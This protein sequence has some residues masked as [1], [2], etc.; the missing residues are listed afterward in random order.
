MQLRGQGIAAIAFVLAG[1]LV[2]HE[3][4]GQ[5]IQPPIDLFQHALQIGFVIGKLGLLSV[6]QAEKRLDHRPPLWLA[7]HRNHV[8]TQGHQLRHEFRSETH[9]VEQLPERRARIVL[10][11]NLRRW[12]DRCRHHRRWRL[13]ARRI[14]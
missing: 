2:T 11:A 13:K 9:I 7:H 3:I 4:H 5:L 14:R 1:V 10:N 8:I 12:S 6:E